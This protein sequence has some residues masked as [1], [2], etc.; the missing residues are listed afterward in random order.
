MDVSVID[1]IRFRPSGACDQVRPEAVKIRYRIETVEV[2]LRPVT[3]MISELSPKC[4]IGRRR[5][6]ALCLFRR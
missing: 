2:R 6:L 1:M 3:L 4:D 5:D